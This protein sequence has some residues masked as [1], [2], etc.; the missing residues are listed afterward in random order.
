MEAAR[1][2]RRRRRPRRGTVERPVNTRLVR[3]AFV[4]VAPALLALL[5]SVSTTGVLPRPTLQPLFDSTAAASLAAQLATVDPSRVPGSLQDDEAARWYRETISTFGFATSEDVWQEDLPDLGRVQLRNVVTVVPGKSPEAIIVAAHRDNTGV[6]QPFGDNASGTAALIEIAR[7]FAPLETAPAP[8]PQRTLV[9]V[10]TDGGAY[11]GAGAARFAA[12]SPYAKDAIAAIVLDGVG[13]SG[14]P[15]L[16]LAGD[17]PRSPAPALVSTALARLREQTGTVPALPSVPTQLVDLGIPY[18]GGEQGRFLANGIA[19]V[20]LTT[21]EKGDPAVPVGD[22]EGPISA[23]RLGELGRAAEALVGSIDSSVGAAFRTPDSIFFRN[24]VASGWA[25]RLTL[26]VALV[27]FALGALDLLVRTSHRRVRLMPAIRALGSR[28]LLWLYAGLLLWLG[29]IAGLF[30][31]SARL[32][33][34][35]YADSVVD[36]PVSGVLL[37]AAAFVLGWLLE[38]R[39]LAPD[40][41]VAVEERLGGY[42]VALTWLCVVAV[43]VALTTPY[44]LIFVLPSLYAWLWLPVRHALWARTTLFAVGLL[45]PLAALL[46]L[47]NQLGLS[48]PRGAFYV[49]GLATVGY[50]PARSVIL[51]LAW[52][53]GAAQIAA[54]ACG[55]YAPYRNRSGRV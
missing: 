34:P 3:V 11:G 12:T 4:V 29:A 33:P 13:G 23:Q 50:I 47:S 49:T 7:G 41:P 36:L 26:V 52:V 44:A 46:V 55:R 27:P 53:A 15:R 2:S 42:A 35:P 39:R 48:L 6:G 20:T 1:P 19:S 14:S 40:R 8:Q 43:V 28:L 24:R 51:A 37:L 18:A 25:A 16:A 22:S 21:Q 45:G 5:F 9:L 54:L 30:P 10:S 17:E 38:R 32:P 31:T